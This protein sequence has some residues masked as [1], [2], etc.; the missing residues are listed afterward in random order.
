[1]FARH[2]LNRQKLGM[3]AHTIILG[4]AGS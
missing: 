3:V 4:K 1:M 2:H